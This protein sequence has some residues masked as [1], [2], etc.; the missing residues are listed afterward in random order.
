VKESVNKL[1]IFMGVLIGA[2][3]ILYFITYHTPKSANPVSNRMP[4]V[5]DSLINNQLRQ[6]DEFK[7][8]LKGDP[9][10]VGHL[11]QIGNLYFDIS[12]PKEA[13]EY[14]E[15]ALAI[16]PNNALVLTDC[17]VMYNQLGQ[18]DRAIEYFDKAIKINPD[19]PQA[20]FNK[21]LISLAV[22]NDST[23]AIKAWRRFIQ[24]TPD[25]IRANLVKRQIDMLET[26]K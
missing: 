14:Y 18:T 11:T 24:V 4:A 25:T 22:K 12:M 5:S 9:N 6:I 2:A 17:G 19:L 23:N 10:N 16:D 3:I 13:V 8:A 1:V 21:G 7:A 20:Y 15:K 26:G